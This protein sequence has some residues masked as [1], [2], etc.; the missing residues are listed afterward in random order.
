MHEMLESCTR[1]IPIYGDLIEQNLCITTVLH[2]TK[3]EQS[4]QSNIALCSQ[5][6]QNEIE[7]NNNVT[8][9]QGRK[10]PPSN[11]TSED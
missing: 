1:Q 5:Q 9:S 2:K 10:P 7:K 11:K 8:I 3:L 6:F 4:S